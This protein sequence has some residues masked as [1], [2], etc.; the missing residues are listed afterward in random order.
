MTFKELVYEYGREGS[1]DA[2][3][4]LTCKVDWFTEKVRETN[5]EL[6]DKFLMKV[7]LLLNPHFTR[8]TA[9]YVVSRL[10]NKDGTKGGHWSY[11]QTTSVMPDGLHEADWHYVLSM[12]YSDYYK[13]GRSDETYIGLAKDFLDDPDAPDGKAKKYYLAMRD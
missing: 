10:E 5:P 2:M 3:E 8:K 4:K 11:E 9:E 12:I 7:D 6:V 1:T 13:S